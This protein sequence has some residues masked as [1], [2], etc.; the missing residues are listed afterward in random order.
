LIRAQVGKEHGVRLGRFW[1]RRFQDPLPFT[2]QS[3]HVGARI[4]PAAPAMDEPFVDQTANKIRK[5]RAVNA[6]RFHQIR[7]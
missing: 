1:P 2:R 5:R 4:V 7:L 6:S 3:H